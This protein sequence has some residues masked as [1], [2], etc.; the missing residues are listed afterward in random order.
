M[1]L[2]GSS[3][4]L[5]ND[6]HKFNELD[7]KFIIVCANSV[8]QFFVRNKIKPHYCICLDADEIDIPQHLD[9]DNKDITLLASSAISGKALDKW[10]GPI[11]FMPYY[12]CTTELRRK[13]SNRL[14]KSVMGGGNSISQALWVVSVIF[15][16]KTVMF[17]GNEFCFDKVKN[18]YADPK[19]AK[20]EKMETIYPIKDVLGRER[21]TQPAHYNYAL[22]IEKVCQDL[23]PPGY[24]IDTSFGLLGRDKD[25]VIHIM[26]FSEAIKKIKWSF[27]MRDKLNNTKNEIERLKILQN[28]KGKYDQSEVYRYNLSEHRERILQLARS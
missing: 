10:K 5:K 15:G 26:E 18:Y 24:F 2:S 6:I 23:C 9:C 8:L 16:S 25:S 22:W 7:D 3:P 27:D 17:A 4:S 28:L 14:G 20:Q 12:S 1:I 19:A 13:L 11:Y 21:W